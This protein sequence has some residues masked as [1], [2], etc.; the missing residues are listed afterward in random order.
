MSTSI[1]NIETNIE[2]DNDSEYSILSPSGSNK[3][4]IRNTGLIIHCDLGLTNSVEYSIN[5]MTIDEYIIFITELFTKS[6]YDKKYGENCNI[7]LDIAN[8][9]LFCPMTIMVLVREYYHINKFIDT[10]DNMYNSIKDK[11]VFYNILTQIYTKCKD[12]TYGT[13]NISDIFTT[14]QK[15]PMIDIKNVI[16]TLLG[17]LTCIDELTMLHEWQIKNNISEDLLD[18]YKLNFNLIYKR[19]DDNIIRFSN[20]H[21]LNEYNHNRNG[22]VI[23]TY[24]KFIPRFSDFTLGVFDN[25]TDYLSKN[26]YISGGSID[27]IIH[28]HFT[29]SPLS[30][31]DIYITGDTLDEHKTILKNLLDYLTSEF[32]NRKQ[33]IY[34]GLKETTISI[35]IEN[36]KRIFQLH[37]SGYKTIQELVTKFDHEYV[38]LVY[39]DKCVFGTYSSIMSLCGTPQKISLGVKP[40]RLYKLISRG[41]DI[42]KDSLCNIGKYC[43]KSESSPNELNDTF[44]CSLLNS[45]Q[46]V[47][48]YYN[49]HYNATSQNSP[50]KNI[51]ELK[52]HYEQKLVSIDATECFDNFKDEDYQNLVNI[53]YPPTKPQIKEH[54]KTNQSN[55]HNCYIGYSTYRN[56][57]NNYKYSCS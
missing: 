12:N 47:Q 45:C 3:P 1:D 26:I 36:E 49:R 29:F 18:I 4:D 39:K 11:S 24:K 35:F 44:D 53:I 21:E 15:Y 51:Y 41:V 10:I 56:N 52:I 54:K 5:S 25:L 32:K 34:F 16:N 30:D 19:Q 6:T 40:V 38:K 50:S 9:K 42:S 31:I 55:D 28:P 13:K 57:Y 33:N 48:D 37:L 7:S 17:L 23:C 2:F 27:N 8:I 43:A 46:E 20:T 22:D 14:A